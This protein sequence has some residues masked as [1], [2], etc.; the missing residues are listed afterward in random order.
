MTRRTVMPEHSDASKW[1]SHRV[2][3]GVGKEG[4]K[5]TVETGTDTK[6][7]R[8]YL[9]GEDHVGWPDACSLA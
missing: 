6:T 9:S 7:R 3:I 5:C 4:E 8:L 2:D 1:F